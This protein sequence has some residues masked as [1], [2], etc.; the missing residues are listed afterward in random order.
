M[1]MASA[2]P[3]L[4]CRGE[5]PFSTFPLFIFAKKVFYLSACSKGAIMCIIISM[6]RTIALVSQ[7]GGSG[8]TTLAVALAVAHELAGG[9]AV[10]ID[11]DPQGSAG[12]WSD[13]RGDDPPVVVAAH[14]PRLARALEAARSAGAS[15]AVI[16]MAPREAGG[17]VEAARC[18]DLVLV[19]CRPSAVDLAAIPASLD[20]SRL[21]ETTAAVV[22]NAVPPR[23]DLAAQATEAVQG[24]GAV[25]VPVTL[26]ARVAHVRAFTAGRTAQETEPRSL[27]ATE[28]KALYQWALTEGLKL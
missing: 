2:G 6:M 12:V 9:D 26:G 15:L 21:A 8:K 5:G 22:L 10:V 3:F 17:A 20:V 4:V 19:P 25:A 28:I 7:K 11:L 14:P 24:F 18:S 23:G 1:F 13:L 27:A 16:D